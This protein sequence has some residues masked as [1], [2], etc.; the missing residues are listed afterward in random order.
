MRPAGPRPRG[1][2]HWKGLALH[3]QHGGQLVPLAIALEQRLQR[4]GDALPQAWLAHQ[5]FQGP[6]R[7]LVLRLLR[8]RFF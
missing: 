3:A 8:Q 4:A 1:C 6:T 5:R 7:T 2:A